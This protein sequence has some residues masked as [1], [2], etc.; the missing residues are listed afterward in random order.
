MLVE[1]VLRRPA[2]GVQA[3]RT[4][5]VVDHLDVE[6]GQVRA[7]VIEDATGGDRTRRVAGVEGHQGLQVIERLFK[8]ES[9]ILVVPAAGRQR[10][11]W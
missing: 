8:H 3:D 6:A 10:C 4:R 7:Q 5:A 11:R 2:H 1:Q 9:T